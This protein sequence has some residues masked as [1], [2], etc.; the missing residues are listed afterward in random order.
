MPP[1]GESAQI[2]LRGRILEAMRTP[3]ATTRRHLASSPFSA[4][5]P[6]EPAKVFEVGDR[7]THDREGLGR[8]TAVE[9]GAVVVDFGERTVRVVAPYKK[10]FLL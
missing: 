8:I 5:E 7:V 4:P 10:L 6:P 1:S 3:R 9:E 2:P